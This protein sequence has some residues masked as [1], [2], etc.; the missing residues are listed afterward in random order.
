MTDPIRV[1]LEGIKNIVMNY[2]REVIVP[3]EKGILDAHNVQ[4]I[5]NQ[6]RLGSM[7]K[8]LAEYK[9]PIR[10]IIAM[11]GVM[12]VHTILNWLQGR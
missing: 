1:T 6:K 9:W 3:R 10:A 8:L 12:L 2:D 7:E 4:H 5:E 11:M